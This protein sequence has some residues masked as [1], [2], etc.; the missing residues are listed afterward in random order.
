MALRRVTE[1][2]S[3]ALPVSTAVGERGVEEASSSRFFR[4]KMAVTGG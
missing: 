4:V 2:G 3:R 1:S